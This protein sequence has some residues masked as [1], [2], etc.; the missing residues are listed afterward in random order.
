VSR[1]IFWKG[2]ALQR[3]EE[4]ASFIKKNNPTRANSF[5]EELIMATEQIAEFP[6]SGGV[7]PE[8]SAFRQIIHAGYRIIYLIV[9]DWEVHIIAVISPYLSGSEIK[10]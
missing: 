6:F 8:N 5:V 3:L 9:D 7:V 10:K 1:S 2:P 4:I